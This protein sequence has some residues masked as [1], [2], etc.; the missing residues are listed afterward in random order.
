MNDEQRLEA[1]FSERE[2]GPKD[3]KEGVAQVMTSVPKTR[4]QDRWLPLPIH[5]PKAQNPTTTD[6]TSYRPSTVPASNGH[7]PI[8]IGRSQT[9]FSPAKAI[10]VGALV[11][12]IGGV[13]L[14]AQPFEQQSSLPGADASAITPTWV[15]G[16]IYYASS[17]TS[18]E[19][20][21]DGAIRH[22]WGY[23]CSPQRWIASDPHL[24]GAVAK[25][26]NEDVYQT[27]NGTMAV[28]RSAYYLHNDDGG[29]ACSSS[30]LLEGSGLYPTQVTGETNVC[31]GEGGYAGLSAFVVV[32]E[33]LPGSH[34]FV[35]LIFSGDFP[36]LPEP[37][38]A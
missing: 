6:T 16:N 10:A 3:V 7:T 37:P 27:D 19:S 22:D 34:S 13:M 2:V 29:W 18:P 36:P 25:L 4:Q 20:E 11:F 30:N 28:N 14:I 9:M 17:C 1:W 5:R 32:D 38:A 35:G 26:W 21:T 31:V 15:T 33:S 8:V 24:S 23:E 12:A